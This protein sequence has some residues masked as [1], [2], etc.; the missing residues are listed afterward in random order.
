M[1]MKIIRKNI[2]FETKQEPGQPRAFWVTGSTEDIDRD[3][4][5][6]LSSGWQF[7][8]FLKNPVIPWAHMYNQPPVAKALDVR[9]IDKK[10]R[11]LIQFATAEE[12]AFA[13]TIY[14]LY[15]GKYLNA[16]SVGFHPIRSERVERTVNGQKRAGYD[17]IENELWEVSAC[18]VPS[19]PNALAEAKQK[20]II[21]PGEFEGLRT[22]GGS[23]GAGSLTKDEA[24]LIA[25]TCKEVMIEKIGKV[26]DRRIKYHLG[27]VD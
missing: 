8:N 21:T 17:F 20:G 7:E 14:R 3:G 19:N 22:S 1:S 23:E 15:K 24:R 13:D 2:N 18:T 16:F 10:L 27:T 26:V 9:V 4:D 11:L 6:I 25:R 12:Y 5:R